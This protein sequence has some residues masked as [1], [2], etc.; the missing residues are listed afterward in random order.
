MNKFSLPDSVGSA[1][2]HGSERISNA[3]RPYTCEPRARGLAIAIVRNCKSAPNCNGPYILRAAGA[4]KQSQRPAVHR[5]RMAASAIC[6]EIIRPH[7]MQ[8][9]CVDYLNDAAMVPVGG[10]MRT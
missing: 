10:Y 2:L 4:G 3:C 7:E 5:C 9:T 1:E 6:D 8:R